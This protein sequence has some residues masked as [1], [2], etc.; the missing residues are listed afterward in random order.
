MLPSA[1]HR[2]CFL[3][4]PDS[5]LVYCSKPMGFAMCGLGPIV[6]GYSLIATHR[7]IRSCAD[8]AGCEE[9]GFL[10]F[11]SDV[12]AKLTSYYGQ[13]LLAEHG[14]MPVC[15]DISNDSDP[16]C[17][18]AHFLMFPGT[19]AIED[20]AISYFSR[21]DRVASLEDAI[22]M[23]RAYEEYFLFSSDP[24]CFLVMGGS[25]RIIRQLA[26]LIV[27]ESLGCLEL[28]DWRTHAKRD[29]AVSAAMELRGL[30]TDTR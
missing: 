24:E 4:G 27:A 8:A 17:Y 21:A 23:A 26:R 12:R 18:H 1:K 7:H 28:A 11:A 13:C 20:K 22:E 25:E 14:R 19:P 10:A 15:A 9:Y 5:D 2:D 3:C 30:F 29:E 16:H 6:R